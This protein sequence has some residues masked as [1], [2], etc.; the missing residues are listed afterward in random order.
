MRKSKKL[1][2]SLVALGVAA[3][4]SVP[5]GAAAITMDSDSKVGQTATEFE[6]TSEMLGGD[7]V[8]TV[9]DSMTLAYDAVNS[10]FSKTAQVNAKG[11]I[12][13]SKKLSIT[14][15]TS[16]TYT[17]ND[18]SSV[19]A[20]GTVTFG[21]TD[22]DNQKTEWSAAELQAAGASGENKDITSKVPL[23]NV[24]YIGDYSST[25]NFNI[26]LVAAN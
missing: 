10:E 4:M 16:I 19:T 13:P 25:I 2:G 7:L 15:P 20:A 24:K 1:L 18:N 9:P 17:H 22:G 26:N 8:V 23:S 11:N 3:S 14:V 6:V 21:T 5:V 12:N